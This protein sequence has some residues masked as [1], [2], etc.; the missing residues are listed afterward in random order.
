MSS[1]SCLQIAS[2]SPVPPNLRVVELSAWLNRANSLERAS[3][4]MPMPVS[5]TSNRSSSAPSPMTRCEPMTLTLPLSVN[6]TALPIRLKS[7]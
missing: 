6:L 2:P 4:E 1:V 3:S 5:R 7:I